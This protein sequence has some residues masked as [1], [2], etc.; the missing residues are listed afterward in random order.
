MTEPQTVNEL[1]KLL[2][3]TKQREINNGKQEYMEQAWADLK[4]FSDVVSSYKSGEV[5][6]ATLRYLNSAIARALRM[7]ELATP[8]PDPI[9]P[10]QQAARVA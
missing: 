4:W 6:L 10:Q 1:L 5:P 2:F 8:V 7:I 3:E 9:P